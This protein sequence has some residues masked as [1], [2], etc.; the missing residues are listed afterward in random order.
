M[1]G[2]Y[3]HRLILRPMGQD[4][5]SPYFR[6]VLRELVIINVWHLVVCMKIRLVV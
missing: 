5:V 1:N 6:S 3:G 2:M 4:K